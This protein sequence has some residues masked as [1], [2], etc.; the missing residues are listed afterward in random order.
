MSDKK[1]T[2]QCVPLREHLCE[3][4]KADD[5]RYTQQFKAI[6][7]ALKVAA[8]EARAKNAE[9]NDVRHRFIPREVFDT[10]KESQQRRARAIIVT[11]VLMGLTIV[12][13]VIQILHK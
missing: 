8:K 9:L 3:L 10:Y 13:L 5:R 2:Q 1:S 12:G 4:R 11:F 7:L 6:A